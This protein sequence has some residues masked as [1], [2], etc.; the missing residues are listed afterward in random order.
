MSFGWTVRPENSIFRKKIWKLLYP[1]Y[2]RE[3][4]YP[5]FILIFF[6]KHSCLQSIWD[7][8]HFCVYSI[9]PYL[10]AYIHIDS[11]YS[12]SIY[13][14]PYFEFCIHMSIYPY[15]LFVLYL[16]VMVKIASVDNNQQWLFGFKIW[17]QQHWQ[18]RAIFF[19]ALDFSKHEKGLIASF[20]GIVKQFFVNSFE[21]E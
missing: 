5:P 21:M 9:W 11:L 4:E 14:N 6:N 15:Y 13:S 2:I 1:P 12:I 16:R 3:S 20:Q 17:D 7:I 10:Y 8:C 18:G 19:E